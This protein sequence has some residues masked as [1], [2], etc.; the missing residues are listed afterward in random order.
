MRNPAYAGRSFGTPTVDAWARWAPERVVDVDVGVRR[1]RGRE[2]RVVLLL[3]RMEAQVLQQ[4]HLAVAEPPKRVLRPGAKR[5]AGHGN[6]LAKELAQPRAHGSEPEAV[7][8][9]AVRTAEVAREDDARALRL[10]VA[11]RRDRGAD[12]RVVGDLAVLERDV[13]VDAEEDALARGVQVADGQLVHG[14]IPS[15]PGA[16]QT[17]AAVGSRW[18]TNAVRSATRQL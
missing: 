11:D 17:A 9:L 4:Q 16:G 1:E 10:K 14:S 15:G 18:A 8:D 12:A 3:L 7:A 2:R 13:E 6:G 5:V